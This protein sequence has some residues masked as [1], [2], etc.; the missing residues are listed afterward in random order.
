[1]SEAFRMLWVAALLCMADL[2]GMILLLYE[3][4]GMLK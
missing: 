3:I 1:M 4:V 2:M